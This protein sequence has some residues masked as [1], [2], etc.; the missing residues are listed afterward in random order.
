MRPRSGLFIVS[1]SAALDDADGGPQRQEVAVGAETRDLSRGNTGY[2][3]VSP[4]LLPFVNIGDVRLH[5]GDAVD[6]SA[7]RSATLVWVYAPGLITMAW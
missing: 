2:V 4:E 7:S 6:D 5:R 1:F 3:R